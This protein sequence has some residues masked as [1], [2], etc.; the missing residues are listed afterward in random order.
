MPTLTRFRCAGAYWYE[1]EVESFITQGLASE[2][3]RRGS[4]AN[5]LLFK[6]ERQLIAVAAHRPLEVDSPGASRTVMS[7]HM[8]ALAIA[9]TFQGTTL[10]DGTQ[11]S[12]MVLRA[13]ILDAL[14]N[15][16]RDPLI[17]GLVAAENDRSRRLCAREGFI[18]DAVHEMVW[19]Q[20]LQ[21]SMEYVWVSAAVRVETSAS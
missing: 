9:Q 3:P 15:R 19:S 11:L 2:I 14:G 21:R 16:G 7:T 10:S 6:T 4:L 17:V 13:A 8:R 5:A 20:H 12:T 18:E 1:Q